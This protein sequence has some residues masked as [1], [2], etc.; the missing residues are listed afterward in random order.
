MSQSI[1]EALIWK[2]PGAIIT[3]SNGKIT[4]WQHPTAQI[5][6]EVEIEAILKEHVS[7]QAA[8]LY[9]KKRAA[10][11]PPAADFLD[12]QVKKSNADPIIQAEGAQQE[13]DYFAACVAVK[14]KYPKP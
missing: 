5:P 9:K 10:E 8:V 13:K 6:D 1:I 7:A 2:Y 12:A 11:Y 3:T 4:D 14:Q